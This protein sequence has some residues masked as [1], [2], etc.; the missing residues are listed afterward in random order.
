MSNLKTSLVRLCKTPAG[1]KRYPAVIGKNGRIKPGVALVD[2]KEREFPVGRYQVRWYEGRKTS[3][4]DVGD[5]PMEAL[6][7]MRRQAHL[8]LARD[9]SKA[10]GVLL[11][12]GTE[13]IILARELSR[14]VRAAEDRG[15]TV[16]A[17][18]YRAA[19]REFLETIG[20]TYADEIRHED[21]TK[22]QRALRERGCSD[23]T[24]HNRHA[25]VLAFLRACG[26]DTKALSPH[27]PRYEKTL[28][29]VYTTEEMKRF[30]Q[31]EMDEKLRL[32]FQILLK[33]GLREQ[34]AMYLE[35]SSLSLEQC[36]L[37]VK[38]NPRYRFKVKDCEARD[39]P[40]PQELNDRLKLYREAHPAL[41]LVT[42]TKSDR[43][44]A[45]LLRTLKRLVKKAKLNC[46]LC[47]GCA[48]PNKECSNWFLHKFR[49]TCIT[50]WLRSGMDLRTV[51]KLSGHSDLDSV[52][53]YLSPAEDDVVRTHVNSIRW[54]G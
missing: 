26:L 7:A 5:H 51:M 48:G 30:F 32:T 21:L 33:C 11:D 43:P 20:K 15:S 42:G 8:L 1:W 16:A 54:E 49:A 31:I 41:R 40:I 45:K 14:F 6:N 18:M 12:E 10:A 9:E 39:I 36:V 27:R 23:R 52:M 34:E 2:G 47:G 22:F 25:N 3:Y 13:R 50:M 44:N 17:G 24:V 35:W 46:G 19:G 38:E 28:P 37:R 29:E 53:R 4:K